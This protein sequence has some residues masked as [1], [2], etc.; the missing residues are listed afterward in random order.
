VPSWKVKC[1]RHPLPLRHSRRIG[2]LDLLD[3]IIPC[4]FLLYTTL[5]APAFNSRSYL[6]TPPYLKPTSTATQFTPDPEFLFP[7]HSGSCSG[8]DR[9]DLKKV[10]GG[11][12]ISY[13]F[14]GSSVYPGQR[15]TRMKNSWLWLATLAVPALGKLTLVQRDVPSVVDMSIQRKEVSDPVARDRVRR[16]KRSSTVSQ[17]LDNEVCQKNITFHSSSLIAALILKSS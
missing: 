9:A 7:S 13:N 12:P 16:M 11:L 15:R 8:E 14:I 5:P 3:S 1:I 4:F 6:E 10:K 17:A 2:V